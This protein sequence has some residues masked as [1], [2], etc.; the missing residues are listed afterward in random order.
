V[1]VASIDVEVDVSGCD[2]EDEL[3]VEVGVWVVVV[4]LSVCDKLVD[5]EF[6]SVLLTL[7]A[8]FICVLSTELELVSLVDIVVLISF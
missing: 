4:P 1:V 2:V 3:E 6:V 7:V 8:M 5:P